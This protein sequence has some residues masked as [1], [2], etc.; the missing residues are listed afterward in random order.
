M[1]LVLI[2]G[3]QRGVIAPARLGYRGPISKGQHHVKI[4]ITGKLAPAGRV[5]VADDSHPCDQDAVVVAALARE[6]VRT[7]CI[8][9]HYFCSAH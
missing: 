6:M 1:G 5:P 8:C 3:D 4:C 7:G 2:S 9:I